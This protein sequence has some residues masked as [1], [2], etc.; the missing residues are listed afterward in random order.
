MTS[1]RPAYSFTA[2]GQRGTEQVLAIDLELAPAPMVDVAPVLLPAA[3]TPSAGVG[4]DVLLTLDGG[5]GSADVFAGTVDAIRHELDR[6]RISAVD[7]GGKLARSRPAVT[8]E[9]ATVGTVVR[10]LCS[11]A[12]VEVDEVETGPV[13]AF[14][15][16]DP[17]RSAL[18][19]VARLAGWVGALARFTADGRLNATVPNATTPDLALRYGREITTLA[20]VATSSA[21]DAVVVA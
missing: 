18:H 1:L 14:Y 9:Q 4:D 16:A 12:G 7:G 8:Y 2:G 19:H 3:A 21:V 11:D 13:L 20:Q 6:V 15:A 17:G 5:E 10:N